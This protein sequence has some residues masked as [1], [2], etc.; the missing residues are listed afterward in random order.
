[1]MAPLSNILESDIIKKFVHQF[2]HDFIMY[3]NDKKK[4]AMILIFGECRKN[5]VY[6]AHVYFQRYPNRPISK[7]FCLTFISS[8]RY[9]L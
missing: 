8:N 4:T 3:S 6:A 5:T 9:F 2:L 1:M 7:V